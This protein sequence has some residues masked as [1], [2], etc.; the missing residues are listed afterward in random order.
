MNE[1][2]QI[3]DRLDIV[4]VISNYV[5]LKQA[6]SNWKGLSPFKTEKTASFMVS[7][8]KGIWHD[9]SSGQGGDVF[10]FVMLM[11]GIEF[12]EALEMLAK[13]A[14]VELKP[15]SNYSK[16]DH[17]SKNSIYDAVDLAMKFYHLN[18]SKNKVALEYVVNKRNLS[19]EIIQKYRIGYSPDDWSKLSEYLVKKG[20]DN[21]QLVSAGLAKSKKDSSSVYDVF[22]NRIMFPIFDTQKRAIGFSARALDESENAKYINTPETPIYHKSNAI[23]GLAQAKDSIRKLEE[24]ILVEGNMDVLALANAGYYNAVAASGTAITLE[25]LRILSRLTKNIK[26]CFDADSAG[27]KATARALEIASSLDIKLM[28]IVLVDAKDP[29]ELVGRDKTA[30][31]KLVKNARYAPDYIFDIANERFDVTS[32]YGKKQFA[33]F[34]LPT[35]ISLND[36]IELHHYA[37]LLA[38]TIDVPEESIIKKINS[39][40]DKKPVTVVSKPTL[41]DTKPTQKPKRTLSQQEKIERIVL[42]LMLANLSLRDV[43]DDIEYQNISQLHTEIF[44]VLRAHPKYDVVKIAKLLPRLSDY[45]KILSLRGEQVYSDLTEHDARLEAFTQIHRLNKISKEKTK[46]QLT[47]AIAQAESTKDHATANKLLKTYQSLI[48][49][50]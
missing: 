3:K 42:E 17:E 41:D 38:Q 11:E 29:D 26:L 7:S 6:G 48:N 39:S 30:W 36:E 10:S 5:P 50:E 25:Q 27:E 23:Y 19:K 21:Q 15:R 45:V 12:R 46:R 33:A 37:K 9:F 2:E 8:E 35:I 44:A 1:V 43:L 32:A 40:K 31:E 24:V 18:L 20:Y 16:N 14:G 49:E 47:R 28:V 13:R 34:T 4:D 22:R